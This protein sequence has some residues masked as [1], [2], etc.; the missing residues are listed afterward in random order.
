MWFSVLHKDR[1]L[2]HGYPKPLPKPH[3]FT[4][5][6]SAELGLDTVLPRAGAAPVLPSSP[7]I[8]T[9]QGSLVVGAWLSLLFE[10]GRC[11]IHE[12]GLLR[13]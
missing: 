1:Q 12:E 9:K 4:R 7:E 13:G 5:L 3:K 2:K 8:S 6:C 11:L 10:L